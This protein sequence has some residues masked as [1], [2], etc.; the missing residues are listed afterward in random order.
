MAVLHAHSGDFARAFAELG[1][2]LCERTGAPG[3]MTV[4][5]ALD[6]LRPDARL[7]A[8]VGKTHAVR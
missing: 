1:R 6:P 7:A 5:P 8:V 3:W 4:D 2:A